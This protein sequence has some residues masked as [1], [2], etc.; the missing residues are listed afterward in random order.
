MKDIDYTRGRLFTKKQVGR[1]VPQLTG[2]TYRGTTTITFRNPK[3]PKELLAKKPV[4][5][6]P[7]FALRPNRESIN[8]WEE[9]YGYVCIRCGRQLTQQNALR[10]NRYAVQELC[11]HCEQMLEQQFTNKRVEIVDTNLNRIGWTVTVTPRRGDYTQP[12]YTTVH[13]RK[14]DKFPTYSSVKAMVDT[15][16]QDYV[17]WARKQG[18]GEHMNI[19]RRD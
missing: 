6:I 15:V 8:P 9:E 5:S 2:D 4:E 3:K 7:S 16:H 18:A 14:I 12:E 19:L 1:M 10:A 13:T 17:T 11:I